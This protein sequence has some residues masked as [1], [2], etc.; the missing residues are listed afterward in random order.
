MTKE[1]SSVESFQSDIFTDSSS[2]L[3]RNVSDLDNT[4]QSKKV[5]FGNVEVF[6]LLADYEDEMRRQT[7]SFVENGD[8]VRSHRGGREGGYKGF[9]GRS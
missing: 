8:S 4:T 3:S 9:T 5:T 7:A 6:E 1:S 2:N